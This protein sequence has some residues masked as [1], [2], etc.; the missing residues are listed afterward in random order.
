M[1]RYC[2]NKIPLPDAIGNLS[3][4]HAHMR[5]REGVSVVYITRRPADLNTNLI[6]TSHIIVI[7]RLSGKNDIMYLENL[8]KGLGDE[9][10]N[11]KDY[12]YIILDNTK[13]SYKKFP[14]LKKTW[15]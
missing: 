10:R 13:G 14:A 1:N 9:I 15:K 3:D 8:H 5:N 6:E 2:P 4:N 11:L 12:E 7:F